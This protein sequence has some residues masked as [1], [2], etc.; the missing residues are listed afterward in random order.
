VDID[1]QFCVC[2]FTLGPIDVTVV[3]EKLR[4]EGSHFGPGGWDI[5]RVFADFDKTRIGECDGGGEDV[6]DYGG[7]VEV[8]ARQERL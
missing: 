6:A 3:T 8:F 7:G 4:Y 1:R 2:I 5:M